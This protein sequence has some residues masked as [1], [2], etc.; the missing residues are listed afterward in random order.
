[1]K[2]MRPP[3]LPHLHNYVNPSSFLG[4]LLSWNYKRVHENFKRFLET[5]ECL[6]LVKSRVYLFRW[7]R[8]E[9]TD[10]IEDKGKK[11]NLYLAYVKMA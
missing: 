11:S 8:R 5:V 4:K 3:V 6:F 10:A 1:M 2:S 9:V 7:L